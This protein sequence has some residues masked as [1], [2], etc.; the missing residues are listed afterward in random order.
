[1]TLTQDQIDAFHAA[2][3]LRYG[4]VLT[5]DELELYRREYD[6]EFAKTDGQ[7]GATNLSVAGS[8]DPG[9]NR[10]TKHRMLQ[11]INMSERNIHFRRLVYNAKILD[12]IED[13]IGP[14]IMMFHDQALLK[15]AHHGGAVT[16][17]QDN[18]Y[19]R[20]RPANL[21]SCWITLDD[22][23]KEN[24]AMQVIPGSHLKPVWH[25]KTEKSGALLDVEKIADTSKSVVCEMSAGHCMFHHC[26]T[27]HY[28]QPNE[29]PNQRRA[30]A[31][32]FMIPGTISELPHMKEM[33]V[34]FNRPM[35][36]MRSQ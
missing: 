22:V 26:Q 8:Q 1:M 15:P 21:V 7:G 23:V 33:P 3:Y 10:P 35:L 17:H 24:G 36:R 20:C 16:W 11:I 31:I 30:F 4:Q 6:A 18:G 9:A 5:A 27:L 29:T 12:V 32:H 28:T 34:G 14:N 2:G 25:E 19:W 13:L